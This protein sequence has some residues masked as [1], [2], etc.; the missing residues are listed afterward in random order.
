MAKD[1]Y[2]YFRVEAGE[3]LE[4]LNKGVLDLEKDHADIEL[5]ELVPR[6]LRLAHTLKGAARVVKH[7]EIAELIHRVED[8]LAPYRATT[9]GAETLV[10]RPQVDS[11]LADLD[12]IKLKLAQLPLALDAEG[13][14]V[15]PTGVATKTHAASDMQ[16]MQLRM[17]RADVLELDVLLEGLGEIGSELASLRESI[18]NMERQRDLA[19]QLIDK[20]ALSDAKVRSMAEEVHTA[21]A[22][23]GRTMNT[24]VERIE[25]E[26]RQARDATER[27]KL[28]PVSSV[29]NTLERTVRDAAHSIGKPV[30]FSASGGDVRIA[31][32]VLDSVQSALIQVVRNAVVHG[33]ETAGERQ[34][35]GKSAEG[36]VTLEVVRRGY[37]AWFRCSDDGGGVNLDAVKQAML[38]K[39]VNP[40]KLQG[41]SAT[42][43]LALLLQGGVTTASAITELAGRGVGLDVVREV[44][45]RYN[46]SVVAETAARRGTTIE[47]RVPLSL[48]T[49]EVLMVELEGQIVALPLDAVRCTLRVAATDLVQMQEGTAI[50]YEGELIPLLPLTLGSH[51]QPARNNTKSAMTAVIVATAGK[52]LAMTVS[53]LH[54]IDTIVLRP[55]PAQVPVDP[56]VLGMHLDTGGNPRLVLDTEQFAALRQIAH[57][58]GEMRP[59]SLPILII[60]DSLTTRMLESSI[61]ESAGFVVELAASAEEGLEMAKNKRYALFLVDV[62]MPG[63]DGFS[64]VTTTRADPVL[65]ET[66]SIL[67]TSCDSAEDRRRGIAVGAAAYIV[68]SEFDQAKFLHCVSALV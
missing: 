23:T 24:S 9:Q 41:L 11:V 53:R 45:Q 57:S 15:A 54:G 46:G 31:G 68:K 56:I 50:M 51:Q 32:E 17:A 44:A 64:F 39:G 35:A 8:T 67:V 61:L 27:L 40:S 12:V 14:S 52:K 60:D 65:C 7:V 42:Q 38:R 62:E 6:L 10:P 36:H 2:R 49:L 4:Q 21:I 13:S 16:D 34:A 63:M 33:I 25:R 66:P 1:P 28:V 55:L 19:A 43:L 48:A 26:L 22:M 37:H 18:R 5:A 59:A 29:F 30:V 47:L 3:L 58:V 20:L